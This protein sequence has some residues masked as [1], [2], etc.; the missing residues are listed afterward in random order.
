MGNHGA[1]GAPA[2]LP[3]RTIPHPSTRLV[4]GWEPWQAYEAQRDDLRAEAAALRE[5]LMRVQTE[6]CRELEQVDRSHHPLQC[7]VYRGH[8]ARWDDRCGTGGA[9]GRPRAG[10]TDQL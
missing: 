7:A 3:W 4:K 2:P 9:E 1:G 5:G 6:I 10:R 8:Y